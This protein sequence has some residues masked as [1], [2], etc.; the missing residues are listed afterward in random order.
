MPNTTCGICHH[1]MRCDAYGRHTATHA[2]EIIVHSAD[3]RAKCVEERNV[4]IYLRRTG[5]DPA[6]GPYHITEFACC[7]AC[8]KYQQCLVLK[9]C[10]E[11]AQWCEKCQKPYSERCDGC[12]KTTTRRAPTDPN[13]CDEFIALHNVECRKHWAAVEPWF[14]LKLAAPKLKI[15]DRMTER[16][17]TKTTKQPLERKTLKPAVVPS[18]PDPRN[19]V[20]TVFHEIFDHYYDDDED[21]EGYDAEAH[22]EQRSYTLKQMLELV[23]EKHNFA[24]KYQTDQTVKL[25]QQMERFVS[26]RVA[27]AVQAVQDKLTESETA[28]FAARNK[29]TTLEASYHIDSTEIPET[30]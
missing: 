5:T 1:E 28:L 23:V 30:E 9:K 21:D 24:I 14:N 12:Q 8:G 16:K 15:S 2:R 19:T 29:I 11:H 3:M 4:C 17:N 18:G 27:R 13:K 25:T 22:T 20:A 26:E 10:Y 6:H 7:L